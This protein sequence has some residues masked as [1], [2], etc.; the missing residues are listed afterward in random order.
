MSSLP[1]EFT[2]PPEDLSDP[3]SS[4]NQARSSASRVAAVALRASSFLPAAKV[5]A[6]S[7]VAPGSVP[8]ALQPSTKKRVAQEI[9][10]DDEDD[11]ALQAVIALEAKLAQRGNQAARE[12]APR[13]APAVRPPVPTFTPLA[14]SC[15]SA[16]SSAVGV[17]AAVAAATAGEVDPPARRAS[18]LSP[19][20]VQVPA[21]QR[22]P[23]NQAVHEHLS[24]LAAD[25]LRI[26]RILEDAGKALQGMAG[27]AA[28]GPPQTQSAWAQPPPR[29]EPEWVRGAL[30]G[31]RPIHEYVYWNA[32][33]L[34]QRAAWGTLPTPL[35]HAALAAAVFMPPLWQNNWQFDAYHAFVSSL[36]ERH[37]WPGCQSVPPARDC[38]PAPPTAASSDVTR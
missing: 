38:P 14:G 15:G 6:G 20:S 24:S 35:A 11:L 36:M 13:A 7:E 1:L 27:E 31:D 4:P 30:R 37:G 17:P 26:G 3:S 23:T 9:N 10:S 29:G 18:D 8:A 2:C 33:S 12:V 16:S 25:T 5:A 32:L 34:N 21:F 28:L 22:S 19:P